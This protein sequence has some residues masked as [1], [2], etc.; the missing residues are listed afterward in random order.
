MDLYQTWTNLS[1]KTSLPPW[2]LLIKT[3]IYNPKAIQ[4]P[5][6]IRIRKKFSL[7]ASIGSKN[8]RGKATYTSYHL[9]YTPMEFD[10][11]LYF[12]PTM[13]LAKKYI[14]PWLYQ[15]CKTVC[16]STNCSIIKNAPLKNQTV[17]QHIN[18]ITFLRIMS[19]TRTLT[20]YL[21]WTMHSWCIARP[22]LFLLYNETL[23]KCSGLNNLTMCYSR[24]KASLMQTKLNE[25]G[26]KSH[27]F[28]KLIIIIVGKNN[29]VNIYYKFQ[30]WKKIVA[31][32]PQVLKFSYNK[33]LQIFYFYMFNTSFFCQTSTKIDYLNNVIKQ[34]RTQSKA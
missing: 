19:Q 23:Q 24:A 12:K 3:S 29:F 14:C 16:K 15:R 27:A 31:L 18:L 20:L 9:Q 33:A 13:I 25:P 28:F 22:K 8:I 11:V 6:L 32:S 21:H 10:E 2:N 7:T 5:M 1:G 30:H 34:L 4:Y 17:M 26:G